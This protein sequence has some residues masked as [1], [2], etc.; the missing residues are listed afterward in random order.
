LAITWWRRTARVRPTYSEGAATKAVSGQEVFIRANLGLGQG[1]A[2]V[3]TCDFTDGYV[4]INGA[5]R[6]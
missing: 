2:R 5:Y 6:S 3:W 4:K 1:R